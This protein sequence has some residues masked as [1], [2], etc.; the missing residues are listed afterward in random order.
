MTNERFL[1]PEMIFRPADLGLYLVPF[2]FSVQSEDCSLRLFDLFAQAI[3][4]LLFQN[5]MLQ[6][7]TTLIMQPSMTQLQLGNH[8]LQM[9]SYHCYDS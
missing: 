1:V 8:S 5:L 6:G 7:Y 3:E 2:S 9:C 4:W